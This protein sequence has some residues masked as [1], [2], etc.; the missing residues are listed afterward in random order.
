MKKY[1]AEFIG[2]A[3]LVI[4][5]C[6][7]VT[8]GGQG[9]ALGGAAPMNVLATLPIAFAFG[10]GVIA[11]AY[12]IGPV[13]GCHINPA[14][15]A[16]VWA[17]GRMPTSD[18]VGYIVAQCLGAI[19][20]AAIL[21]I[22]LSGK[23]GGYDL[24]AGG[25]GQNGWKTYSTGSAAL[26]EFAGTFLFLVAILGATSKAGSGPAAGLAIGMTLVGIHIVLIPVTGTSVN[27][28][29]SLGPALFVGGQ[30]M[31]QLWL[32]LIM[33]ILGGLAAGFLFRNKTLEA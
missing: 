26:A 8:L 16:G 31:A 20:G 14:V 7:A 22:I 33:P 21:Y 3:A 12:G 28:A 15:T 24:A 19:T 11:M 17:A 25:L 2:T 5:G 18:L 30:A 29:R 4:I 6:G 23:V 1:L 9:A 13:S 10:I 32:F 27:P